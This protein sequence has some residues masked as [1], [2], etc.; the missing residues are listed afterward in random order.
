MPRC[1]LAT[2]GKDAPGV[3]AA[4]R[5][6]TRVALGRGLSVAATLRGFPGIL[7]RSIRN[8]KG[9]EVGF[10]LGKGGS[11]LGS[12]DFRLPAEAK[13]TVAKIAGLLKEYDLVVA[14]GGLGSF[15]ILN[16]VYSSHDLGT[17][18]TMFIPASVE[19]EF[20][21]PLRR[22]EG[23]GGVHAEAI[24]ADTAAN[25]AIEAIDRL[26]DQSYHTRT[27]FV[28]QLIGVKSNFLPIQVGI[29][30][31]ANRIYL[32]EFPSLR[33]EAKDEIGKLFESTF[34]PNRVHMKE[35]VEW[36]ERMFEGSQKPYLVLIVPNGIPVGDVLVDEASLDTPPGK[37]VPEER[38]WR[39]YERIVTSQA[40]VE[41][42][43]LRI[44]DDL[45]LHFAG[46]ESVH[47]RYVVLD[48]LQRGG[49]PTLRDRILGTMYGE[50]A[51][52]EYLSV[53]KAQDF[54]RWGN[55]NLLAVRDTCKVAWRSHPREAVAHVFAGPSPRAGGLDPLPFFRQSRGTVSGYRPLAAV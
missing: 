13:D 27:V 19:N 34:D 30:C 53:V 47:I 29:A 55:L 6:A 52:E 54:Q 51:I 20:L 37:G 23:D 7:N 11:L 15:S 22:D 44:V 1:L 4:L 18:T 12:T 40:P 46:N 17:T 33:R 9:P 36:I 5:A 24:G 45:M 14:T 35:L 8:L 32:P 3:N 31:G 10:I 2:L 43:I 41:L 28:I 50:A 49:A 16:R 25:V 21:N 39:S 42:T 26:R 38:Q 48:D